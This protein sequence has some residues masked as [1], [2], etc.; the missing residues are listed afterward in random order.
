LSGRV[1]GKSSFVF[2]YPSEDY[3]PLQRI[4]LYV[5]TGKKLYLKRVRFA[6]EKQFGL[7]VF[8]AYNYTEYSGWTSSSNIGDIELN[9]LLKDSN[10][11]GNV[12]TINV[13][14]PHAIWIELAPYDSWWVELAIE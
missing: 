1:G 14:N 7:S 13:Y 3:Y 6:F 8:A 11:I 5:P 2:S 4:G 10:V 12:L 9:V